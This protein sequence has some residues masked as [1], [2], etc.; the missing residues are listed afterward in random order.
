M[1]VP[2]ENIA[3]DAIKIKSQNT[4]SHFTHFNQCP[5]KREE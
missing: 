1:V 3:V 2:P 4:T 5:L